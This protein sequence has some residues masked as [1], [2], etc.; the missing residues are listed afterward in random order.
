MC[1]LPLVF[2]LFWGWCLYVAVR[3][4]WVTYPAL[5]LVPAE[6]QQDSPPSD[7]ECRM[8][9][10]LRVRFFSLSILSANSYILTALVPSDFCIFVCWFF[11]QRSQN[12]G[13]AWVVRDLK[14]HPVLTSLA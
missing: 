11:S 4:L 2:L 10:V 14:G 13:M 9:V 12:H 8:L 6:Q 3:W 7:S 1:K 5:S